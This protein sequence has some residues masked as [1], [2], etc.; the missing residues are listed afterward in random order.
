M[1][2]PFAT[3]GTYKTIF[4]KIDDHSNIEF[5]LKQIRRKKENK[6]KENKKLPDSIDE[7]AVFGNFDAGLWIFYSS[8]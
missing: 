5:P 8:N 4:L 1:L 2:K 3:D 6:N 7:Q